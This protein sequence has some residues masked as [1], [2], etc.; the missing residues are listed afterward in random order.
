M[1]LPA[2]LTGPRKYIY[3]SLA[4]LLVVSLVRV[5]T[6]ADGPNEPVWSTSASRA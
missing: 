2:W 3:L 1:K 4:A 5:F 6:G